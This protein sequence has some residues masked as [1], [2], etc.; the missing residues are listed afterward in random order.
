MTSALAV[1]GGP[2]DLWPANFKSLFTKNR[3]FLIGVDRGSLR[4]LEAGFEPRLALGD[5]D[6][7]TK[8]ELGQVEAACPELRYAN[9]VKD[10]TDSEMML[11][12]ALVDYGID[13]LTII[14]AGGGR[15]DHSLVNLFALCE[16][17][18]LKLAERV[19]F[20][21]RQNEMHFMR[22]GPHVF[23]EK[24]EYS[25]FGV[26]NLLPV[27]GLSIKKARYPLSPSDYAYPHM[28]SSNEFVGPDVTVSLEKGLGVFIYSRD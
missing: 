10:D 11:K 25:Y 3:D 2:R 22:P 28:W 24:E 13:E 5:F 19:V 26:G 8:K 16:P 12:A 6:S 20:V 1:L 27:K 9:P 17:R 4:I 7:L 21:D 15:L 23:K 18:F 14:G